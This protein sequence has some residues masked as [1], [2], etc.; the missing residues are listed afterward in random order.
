MVG[1]GAPR[2]S[3]GMRYKLW[4]GDIVERSEVKGKRRVGVGKGLTAG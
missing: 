3:K 2:G 4:M 1:P